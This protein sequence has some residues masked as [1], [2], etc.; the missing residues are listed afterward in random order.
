MSAT[1]AVP[2]VLSAAISKVVRRGPM[3]EDDDLQMAKGALERLEERW[4]GAAAAVGTLGKTRRGEIRATI[5]RGRLSLAHAVAYQDMGSKMISLSTVESDHYLGL[6]ERKIG[7]S[8]EQ[9]S[10]MHGAQASS[11]NVVL[12]DSLGYQALNARAAKVSHAVSTG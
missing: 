1:S 3:D 11:E 4:G 9:L 12:S 7:R 5:L 10:G 6:A 8:L 2:S